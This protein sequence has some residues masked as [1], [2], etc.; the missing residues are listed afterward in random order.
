MHN[1]KADIIAR[2]QREILPLQGYKPLQHAGKP[3]EGLDLIQQA[4]PQQRFPLAAI[5]E[6]CCPDKEDEAPTGGFI[7]ALLSGL[8]PTSATAVWIGRSPIIFPP[9]LK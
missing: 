5:H 2:L 9:A 3:L 8:L 6:F 4:F 1:A 7:A